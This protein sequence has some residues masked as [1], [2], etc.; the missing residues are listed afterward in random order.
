MSHPVT[1]RHLPSQ[2]I[3]SALALVPASALNA[4]HYPYGSVQECGIPRIRDNEGRITKPE[5]TLA[6]SRGAV[7]QRVLMWYEGPPPPFTPSTPFGPCTPCTPCTP[8][9][10]F[11]L[12]GASGHRRRFALLCSFCCQGNR[13]EPRFVQAFWVICDSRGAA[14]AQGTRP[15]WCGLAAKVFLASG[16]GARMAA[17]RNARPVGGHLTRRGLRDLVRGRC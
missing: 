13:R 5:I 3:L 1:S 10:R 9:I 11:R 15:R 4:D 14:G 2:P 17:G 6:E 7:V 16:A 8:F 12:L